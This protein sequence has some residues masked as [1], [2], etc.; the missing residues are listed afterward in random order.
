MA[1]DLLKCCGM[2]CSC[3]LV[4]GIGFFAILISLIHHE[5]VF[6]LRERSEKE[7]KIDALVTAIIINAVCLVGCIGCTVYVKMTD[8]G[9]PVDEEEGIELAK[10]H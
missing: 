3:L 5:N 9:E 1:R 6:L 8:K 4:V 2:Y 7:E 10:T